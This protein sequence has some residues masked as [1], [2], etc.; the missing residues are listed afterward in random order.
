M[1]VPA[2]LGVPSAPTTYS[3]LFLAVLVT[4]KLLWDRRAVT[5]EIRTLTTQ[6]N[7]LSTKVAK[8]EVQYDDERSLKH[9]ANNDLARCVLALDLVQRL[10]LKCTDGA[11]DPLQDILNHLWAELETMAHPARR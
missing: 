1:L 10:A 8:L 9:K 2:S 6:V 3:V 5:S 11:L 7:S 4:F